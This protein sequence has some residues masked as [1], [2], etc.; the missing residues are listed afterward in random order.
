LALRSPQDKAVAFFDE[1]L[2]N[3]ENHEKS[4][5]VSPRAIPIPP[6]PLTS[7]IC[8]VQALARLYLVNNKLDECQAQCVTLMRLD[9]SNKVRGWVFALHCNG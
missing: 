2:K 8:S 9:P 6:Q 7:A 3:N 4:R 1:A 5:L